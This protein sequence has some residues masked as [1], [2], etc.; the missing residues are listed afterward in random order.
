MERKSHGLGQCT[1][2]SAGLETNT[3]LEVRDD[4]AL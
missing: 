4:E 1:K 2:S 3:D